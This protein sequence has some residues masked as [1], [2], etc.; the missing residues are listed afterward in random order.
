M[1]L[2]QLPAEANAVRIVV[3]DSDTDPD[4]WVAVTPPRVPQTQTLDALLGSTTPTM[5]DWEVALQFPCQQPFN[6]RL[7]VA[8]IPEYRIL[9]DRPGA[10]MTSLWQDHFGGGP[11]GWIDLTATGRTLPTYLKDDW[12]QDWGSLEKYTRRDANSVPAQLDTATVPRSGTWTPGPI[13]IAW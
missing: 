9:G 4:Q 6:H 12:S 5:I 8:E 13:N 7:G 2:D 11:L 1:P 3:D 10:V